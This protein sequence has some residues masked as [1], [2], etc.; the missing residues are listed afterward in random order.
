MMH[1]TQLKQFAKIV[2]GTQL[3]FN[4]L[5]FVWPKKVSG[6]LQGVYQAIDELRLE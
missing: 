3:L 5:L 4:L 2:L 6:G 1:S